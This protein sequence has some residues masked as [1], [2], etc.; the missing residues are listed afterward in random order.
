MA[1]VWLTVRAEWRQRWR[2]F[3]AVAVLA[4]LAGGATLVA[5][6]GSRRADT[7]FAR[8]E[9]QLKTTNL[10]VATGERPDPALL[11]RVATW[12]GVEVALHQVILAVAPAG[13]EML[14]G[15]DTIAAAV[16]DMAGDRPRDFNIVEGR[17]YDERRADEL[18]VN[19]AMRDALDADIGDRFSLISLTPQQVETIEYEGHLPAPAGPT[20]R[21]TL[22]GVARSAED[23]S[24]AP[25]PVLIVTPAYYERHGS[26]IGRVEGVGLRV[27]EN[28][29]PEIEDRLR[30]LFGEDVAIDQPED[31][32]AR[33]EDGL[34]VE[35]NGLRAF[36]LVT[37]V[38][39]LVALGQML[40]RHADIASE[41]HGSLRA[42]GMTS[43]E[44][45]ASDVMA[46]LPAA[47]GGAVLAAAG[48]VAGGPLAITGLAR[49]AEPDPGPWFDSVVVPGATVVGLV[50]LIVA[51]LASAL[52]AARGRTLERMAPVRPSRGTAFLA[53]LPPP[54]A[55]GARMALATG[56]GPAALPTGPALAGAAVGIAGVVAT[57]VFGARV[58][59]LLDTPRLWGANYDAVVTTEEDTVSD[60][61]TADRLA[62]RSDVAAVAVFD[63]IDIPIYAG[64]RRSQVEA[65][66]LGARRGTIPPVIL[67]GRAPAA[68]DEVALGD[69]VLDD[70]HV[71]IGD[72]VEVDRDGERAAL[73]V[74][75]RY[76]QPSEDDASSGM[77]VAPRGLEG[78]EGEDGDSGVLVRFTPEVNTDAALRRLR[79]VGGQVEV[80]AAADDAPSNIDNLDELGALPWALAAFLSV[81][82]AIAAAHALVSTT[83]RRRRDLA[84]LRVLGFVGGQVR[85]TL[86]WQA[87]TVA[88]VGLLVGVPAGVIAGRRIWSMLADAV[89][90]VDDWSF[91]WLAVVLAVPA[92]M[93]VAVL[94]AIPTGRAA[95]RVSPSRVLRAE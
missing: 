67:G 84:V 29:L 12:P 31:F 40:A 95:A 21:V 88:S 57:L 44:L 65:V 30:S 76:L 85:S 23:V 79:D 37:A 42:L 51:A 34:A 81:L 63:S 61:R 68:P 14:A 77:L 35:V 13:T 38:A 91:P 50:V 25:D 94:L 16:T 7:S 24:D 58:D 56:R 2:S 62:D 5:L 69:D 39:G 3:V 64:E 27:D 17:R 70:L 93:S 90:I 71:G 49:Q 18:L 74:V 9:E 10:H 53:A 86:R 55:V 28:R 82:A 4:G 54:A 6:I 60:T 92:A 66:T 36:A 33:I 1:A 15:R 89:G 83:R 41:Q 8:L 22:V 32:G 80:T 72:T 19:E 47:A 52:A 43:R 87:L 73:W 48:A 75:G 78:L 20:Q 46:V 45:I 11:R 26:S 59:H